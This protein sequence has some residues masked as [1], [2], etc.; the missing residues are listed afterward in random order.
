MAQDR[1][2]GALDKEAMKALRN[3]RKAWVDPAAAIARE[4]RKALGAV[5]ER[6]AAS[7]ATVP[8]IAEATGLA[9]DRTLWLIATMKKFGQ[10]VEA[11]KDGSFYRYA[12][13]GGQPRDD[14]A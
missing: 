9:V 2:Q 13:V 7:S 10:I 1:K 4:T 14:E 11:E 6:L 8:E 12:L 5:S 3:E